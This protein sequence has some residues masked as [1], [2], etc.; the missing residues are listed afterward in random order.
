ML[1]MWN[2][3]SVFMVELGWREVVNSSNIHAVY[4]E[5]KDGTGN[6][7]L[8][9]NKCYKRNTLNIYSGYLPV[10]ISIEVPYSSLSHETYDVDNS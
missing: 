5:P 10:I 8:Q 6:K 3:F 2:F 9:Q 1:Y 4:L 7:R